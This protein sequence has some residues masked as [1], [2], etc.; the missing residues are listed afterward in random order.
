VQQWF[1]PLISVET[2]DLA[3]YVTG[4]KGGA[5]AIANLCRVYGRKKRD[6]LLPVV[7]L[8]SRTYKHDDYGRIE[9]PDLPIVGWDGKSTAMPAPPD[10]AADEMNDAIPF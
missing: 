10:I 2:G 5:S 9:T 4:S 6:G 8:K 7:A 1:L 3:T